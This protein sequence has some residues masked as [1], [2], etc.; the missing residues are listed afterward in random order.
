[1]LC[2]VA[3][4]KAFEVLKV[5]DA[6]L[7]KNGVDLSK[8]EGEFDEATASIVGEYK[9]N[10]MLFDRIRSEA[11]QTLELISEMPES[12]GMGSESCECNQKTSDNGSGDF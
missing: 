7:E 9:K 3:W 1:V 4:G 8:E 2:C 12:D 5:I 11:Q 6:V 10:V